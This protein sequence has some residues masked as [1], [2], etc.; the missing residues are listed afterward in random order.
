[1]FWD[2]YHETLERD[3]LRELQVTLL[4][5]SV[6]R[7][8]RSPYYETLFAREEISPDKVKVLEDIRRIPFVT[9][10]T[11]GSITPMVSLP[12]RKRRSCGCTLHPV[13]PAGATVIFHTAGDIHEWADLIAR[14]MYMVGV[15]AS[16]VFQNMMTYGLFT[17]GLG[18]TTARKSW[19]RWSSRRVR[20]TAGVRS[21]SCRSS[22]PR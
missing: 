15:R 4:R 9:K 2:R 5:R 19:A 16:D 1:M 17:G 7:A 13:P 20:E 3:A 10:E 22:I 6:D 18:F 12:C 14:C 8:G 21:C 11:S